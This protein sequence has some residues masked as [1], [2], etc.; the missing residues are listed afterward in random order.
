MSGRPIAV[1][2]GRSRQKLRLFIELAPQ[3]ISF[4]SEVVDQRLLVDLFRRI[5]MR[6]V[7]IHVVNSLFKWRILLSILSIRFVSRLGFVLSKDEITAMFEL[8]IN[9]ASPYALAPHKA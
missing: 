5:E 3:I 9:H 8:S 1:L 6:I 7:A 4:G 2:C